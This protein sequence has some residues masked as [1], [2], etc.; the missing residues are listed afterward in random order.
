MIVRHRQS[1][2]AFSILVTVTNKPCQAITARSDGPQA[3][4]LM[5]QPHHAPGCCRG[6]HSPGGCLTAS[7]GVGGAHGLICSGAFIGDDAMISR[8]CAA[9]LLLALSGCSETQQVTDNAA[10]Q[11]GRVAGKVGTGVAESATEFAPRWETVPPGSKEDCIKASGGELNNFYA[12]CRNGYQ[13]QVRIDAAGRRHVLKER[14]IPA[15]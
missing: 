3:A 10:R 4:P 14:P 12:R 15:H 13:E 8:T 2:D 5:A 7:A 11:V 1:S 6:K 9:L